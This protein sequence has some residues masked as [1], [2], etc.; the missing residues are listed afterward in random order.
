MR[1]RLIPQVRLF[2]RMTA[3]TLLWCVAAG[4]AN[5]VTNR[6]WPTIEGTVSFLGEC[7]K[8]GAVLGLIAVAVALLFG[9][10]RDPLGF[11]S[12]LAVCVSALPACLTLV[13]LFLI[14][15]YSSDMS[16]DD[17]IWAMVMLSN[18]PFACWFSQIVARK[19]LREISP[20]K[21]KAKPKAAGA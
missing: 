1:S 14:L 17:A 7:S 6:H 4:V 8:A 2:L 18:L 12:A 10:V 5:L 15:A 13:L 20:E 19:Y 3:L 11:K 9:R 21:R 16:L